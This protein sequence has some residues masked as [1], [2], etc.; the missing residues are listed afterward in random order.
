MTATELNAAC[1]KKRWESWLEEQSCTFA[2]VVGLVA[3]VAP[4]W[5]YPAPLTDRLWAAAL[6][7]VFVMLVFFGAANVRTWPYRREIHRRYGEGGFA[8]CMLAGA[9]TLDA[10]ET[11]DWVLVLVGTGLPHGGSIEV[12]LAIKK[13]GESHLEVRSAADAG[14][15]K[16][17]W[18]KTEANVSANALGQIAG[19]LSQDP[20]PRF[21]NVGQFVM[22]GFPFNLGL[23]GRHPVLPVRVHGNLAGLP[24]RFHSEPAVIVAN[25]LLLMAGDVGAPPLGVGWCDAEGN[26]GLD[27]VP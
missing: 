26:I 22:D 3:A 6:W 20:L 1:A 17:N 2:L 27:T 16:D 18:V 9:R 13:S 4:W 5:A 7:Y 10:D 25:H 21:R 23:L 24:E 8:D 11:I 19:L 14:A 12:T 15:A